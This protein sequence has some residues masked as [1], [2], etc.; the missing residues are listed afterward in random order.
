[1]LNQDIFTFNLF[2]ENTY[3][4][5]NDAKEAFIVDPGCSSPEECNVLAKFIDAKGLKL[6]RLLL[7][8]A[9]LDHILGNDFVY[10]K[11]GLSPYMHKE[12]LDLLHA[13]EY[14]ATFYGLDGAAPSPEPAGFL[15]DGDKIYLGDTEFRVIFTP[16]HSKGSICFYAPAEKKL[17]GGDV[18]FKG[19]I[20]RTDLPGGNFDTLANSI[21]KALFTLPEDVTVYSGHGELTT[22]GY[23]KKH[24]PFVGELA[25]NL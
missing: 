22:I 14:S 2:A 4:L 20:G 9:H 1:M 11:Y 18:L 5:Y 25:Q 17:W 21:Q 12:D 23:E 15:E 19:S 8:H 7:T 10:R 3:L 16:G 6:R 24:N 13:L